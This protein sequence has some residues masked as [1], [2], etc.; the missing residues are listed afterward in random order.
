MLLEDPLVLV[1]DYFVEVIV[2]TRLIIFGI[3]TSEGIEG[4]GSHFKVLV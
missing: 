4:I 1:L 2:F 3:L